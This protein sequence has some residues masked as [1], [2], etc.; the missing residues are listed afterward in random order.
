MMG[1]S[2]GQTSFSTDFDDLGEMAK[3]RVDPVVYGESAILKTAYWF[4]DHY[5]LFI[6]R[7]RSTGL[8]EIEFRLKDGQSTE[9]LRQACGEFMNHLLDQSVRQLV[10]AET[11]SIRDTLL[12]K[13]FLEATIRPPAS[14]ASDETFLPTDRQKY[15]DD[16]IGIVDR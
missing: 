15:R 12:K 16:P 1:A 8:M 2:T 10:L 7:D 6:S 4:T 11:E 5:Y 14:L 3:I 13:A 9:K